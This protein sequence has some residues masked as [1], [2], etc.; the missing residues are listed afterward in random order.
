MLPS[1]WRCSSALGRERIR[2]GKALSIIQAD[3]VGKLR[4]AGVLPGGEPKRADIGGSIRKLANENRGGLIVKAVVVFV[5]VRVEA[6]TGVA[7]GEENGFEPTVRAKAGF[8]GVVGRIGDKH[9]VVWPHGE[10]RAVAINER[11]AEAIIDA[12]L[13]GEFT[14]V[15]V[16]G[17]EGVV[18]GGNVIGENGGVET[19]FVPF[20]ST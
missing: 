12:G 5:R 14:V 7:V 17:V 1:R 18:C 3:L 9:G 11:G 13:A 20:S 19:R 6:A 16:G 15:I 2:S 10:E 8:E 4:L